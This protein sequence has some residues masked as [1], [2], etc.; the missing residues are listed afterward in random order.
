MSI[1]RLA[2]A[3]A[4]AAGALALAPAAGA[5]P[6]PLLGTPHTTIKGSLGEVL[7]A[8]DV[9]GDGREDLVLQPGQRSTGW[10]VFGA[11]SPGTLDVTS[12]GSRGFGLA[13]T[14][15][16][17]ARRW[18]ALGDVN[19][20]GRDD[21]G[22]TEGDGVAKIVF[23]RTATTPVS[24]GSLGPD[25]L[26][27]TGGPA[28]PSPIVRL[29]GNPTGAGD[30]NGDGLD[31]I[32]IP[33]TYRPKGAAA[34][35]IRPGVS[36]TFGREGGGTID[37]ST[38]P[39]RLF[40]W[41]SRMIG[42]TSG[43]RV[44]RFGDANRDGR[45]EVII[46][47]GTQD[48]VLLGRPQ[49]FSAD[50]PSLGAAGVTLAGSEWA[51]SIGDFNGDGVEDQSV[52]ATTGAP[53]GATGISLSSSTSPFLELGSAAR[54]ITLYASLGGQTEVFATGELTGDGAI[55][56]VATASFWQNTNSL[57]ISAPPH[58]SIPYLASANAPGTTDL[59][60]SAARLVAP[61]GTPLRVATTA[62][63]SGSARAQTVSVDSTA[64]VVVST[65]GPRPADTTPPTLTGVRFDKAKILRS[66]TP[67]A[68][69]TARL[70]YGVDEWSFT[71]LEIRRGSTLVITSRGVV[72]P[73]PAGATTN[74]F[75][76]LAVAE[77]SGSCGWF[78]CPSPYA[79]LA[80]GTYTATLKVSDLDGNR[81]AAKTASIVVQ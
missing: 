58:A 50:L 11:A 36:I 30:F 35:A 6:T 26:R 61:D 19:G 48:T 73:Q 60:L 46:T 10:V 25:G 51:K 20:D 18:G 75:G 80:A 14:D 70:E 45:D 27:V 43:L 81:G 33:V 3:T 4:V 49:A 9:N 21:I 42:D 77:T 52:R 2:A 28:G 7:N 71:E 17:L 66:G 13:G 39:D 29:A 54:R 72:E 1:L 12:L 24:L 76:L 44:R 22:I 59:R 63:F 23:G 37:L 68:T 34:S 53:H 38:D 41:D 5:A 47:S 55:D 56:A 62:R 69:T 57:N 64:G 67:S 74:A 65:L 31:D 8:G 78:P 16:T 32:A 15:G 40:V 79:R